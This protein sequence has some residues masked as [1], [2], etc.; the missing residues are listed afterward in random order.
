MCSDIF[1]DRLSEN[2]I[3]TYDGMLNSTLYPKLN[4]LLLNLFNKPSIY[5]K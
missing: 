3:S 4:Y 5:E 1:V 2:W